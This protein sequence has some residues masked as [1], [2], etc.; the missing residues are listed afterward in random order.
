MH[1]LDFNGNV[2]KTFAS[3]A[4]RVNDISFDSRGEFTASCSD[5]G[6]VVHYE[7]TVRKRVARPGR[8]MDTPVHHEHTVSERGYGE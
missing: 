7:Q 4:A 3:H 1:I 8:Y 5:D 2:I 6:R